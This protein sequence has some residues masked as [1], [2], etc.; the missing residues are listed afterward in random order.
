MIP[1]RLTLR[2]FLCYR[3]CP[4]LDFEHVR[5]AC[6][7]GDNGNGK[8]AL[9]EAITWALWGEARGRDG[10]LISLGQ[11][12]MEVDFEFY[13]GEARHRVIRKCQKTG[14]KGSTRTTLEFHIA[15]GGGWKVLSGSTQAETQRAVLDVLKLSY[16]TFVNSAFLMQGRADAFTT[17]S[18]GERKQV[19]AEILNLAQYDSFAE[20]AK[21]RR[22]D[23]RR[24]V[25]MLER[26]VHDAEVELEQLPEQRTACDGIKAE[27]DQREADLRDAAAIRDLLRQ[28][29]ADAAR[30]KRDLED[31]ER[32]RARA[33]DEQA[34][35]EGRAAGR[36]AE[37][38]RYTAVV[39]QGEAIGDGYTRLQEAREAL[40]QIRA[41]A[42][43]LQLQLA[44]AERAR[45]DAAAELEHAE[46]QVERRRAAIE[47]NAALVADAAAIRDG[48]TRLQ[49]ARAE[50]AAQD[51]RLGAVTALERRLRPLRE[52][53]GKAEQKLSSDLA[54]RR[55]GAVRLEAQAARVD[56]LRREREEADRE[57]A[58]LE[59]LERRLATARTEESEHRGTVQALQSQNKRLREEMDELRRKV[60]EL[61]V[62]VEHGAADCPLCRSNLGREGLRRVE[63]SYEAEGKQKAEQFRKNQRAIQDHEA[64]AQGRA[65]EARR[66]EADLTKRRGEWKSRIAVL[67]RDLADAREAATRLAAVR[68]EVERLAAAIAAGSFAHKER[69]QIAAIEGDIA[70]AGYD[71]EAHE[72]ARHDL[73]A[74]A[75]FEA[76]HQALVRAESDLS[77]ARD[78][79]AAEEVA[80]A[81]WRRR[82][83]EAAQRA[84]DLRVRLAG[85][86]LERV[87]RDVE[88]LAVYEARHQDLLAAESRLPVVRDA[89]ASEERTA[90]GW[91]RQRQEAGARVEDVQRRL[92]ELVDVETKL[93]NAQ[94]RVDG[95]AQRCGALR[96]ALG[97]T[98]QEIDRLEELERTTQGR[99]R[100][101]TQAQRERAIYEELVKA[102]GKNGAQALIIDAA[103]PEIEAAAND[104]LARMTNNRMHVSLETQRQ[105]QKGT[106]TETLDIKIAD[107]W[108]TRGYEMFSG[109]EAFRINLALRIALSKLLARRAGAPLPTLVIDEGFGTQDAAGRERLLDAI[110]AIQH[111]FQCLLL[112]THIDEL[113]DLFD[114]RIEVAKNGDGS[115]ARVVAA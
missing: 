64:T 100:R 38:E 52:A 115:I 89:L 109:G 24:T 15:D 61:R 22:D 42:E 85:L 43:S 58:D 25:E 11:N 96:R 23:R 67:D 54:V 47:R 32:A 17:K 31:A 81:S 104:L 14:S 21:E 106:V 30:L 76:R 92:V 8:S 48:Y 114:T 107:E 20:R 70:V 26:Q 73:R 40:S 102:F 4:A 83:D 33:A 99:R 74:F 111:D 108:G 53:V 69:E 27:L 72:R 44:N 45:D 93:R 5:L 91:R 68:A 6:L 50:L 35:A 28:Q 94:E 18:A 105:N 82:R 37:V 77:A 9:L 63:E 51:K 86:P 3:D 113:K 78:R 87:R 2:N 19:L 84:D 97:A 65:Q 71:E 101:L 16:A 60:D 1:A 98:E 56:A 80:A 103:L 10:E 12:E 62:A 88:D 57:Q 41:E 59:A 39:A 110:S 112:I 66:L 13:V 79:L 55:D 34:Q 29:A 49:A 75:E 90:A 7:T 95:L 36:R 46:R